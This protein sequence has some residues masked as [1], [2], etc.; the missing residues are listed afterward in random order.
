MLEGLEKAIANLQAITLLCFVGR[1]ENG[2]VITPPNEEETKK[3]NQLA[4]ETW[5]YL[6]ALRQVIE[7]PKRVLDEDFNTQ[8]F[9]F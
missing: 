2:E 1:D 9:N 7:N 3:V 5:G 8:L 6:L 4:Y